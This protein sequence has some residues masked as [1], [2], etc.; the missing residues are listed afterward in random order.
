MAF[1]LL[2]SANAQPVMDCARNLPFYPDS[3]WTYV[4]G[5][6]MLLI[7]S[8]HNGIN[9]KEIDPSQ[10][11]F[12]LKQLSDIKKYT[13]QLQFRNL[14]VCNE[15]LY[16]CVQQSGA[17]RIFLDGKLIKEYGVFDSSLTKIKAFNP[18]NQPIILPFLD[19][20]MHN[21]SVQY[22]F[23]P[24]LNLRPMFDIFHP[25]FKAGIMKLDDAVKLTADRKNVTLDFLSIG[26]TFMLFLVHFIGFLFLYAG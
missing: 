5:H 7:E 4:E 22:L 15:P 10:P 26:L 24:G 20:G 18:L 12:S 11:A 3:G 2:T 13:L 8:G 6:N 9:G 21:I 25:L 23:Q 16:L 19:T 1:C 14:S 17:S